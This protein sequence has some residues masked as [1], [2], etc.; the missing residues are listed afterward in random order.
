MEEEQEWIQGCRQPAQSK[1]TKGSFEYWDHSKEPKLEIGSHEP[2]E[3]SELCCSS[4]RRG[5]YH[6]VFPE[7]DLAQQSQPITAH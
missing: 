2:W 5:I 1:L 6:K 3:C 7:Q 4:A